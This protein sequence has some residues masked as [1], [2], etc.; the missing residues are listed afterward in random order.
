VFSRL[1]YGALVLLLG[2]GLLVLSRVPQV[3]YVETLVFAALG[4][5]E[6]GVS[7]PVVRLDQIGQSVQN[8]GQ[9]QSDNA[10]LRAEVDSLT[11]QAVLVP[12]LQRENALLRAELGFSRDNPQF[13]WISAHLLGFD[14]SNLVR[15][16]IL[17]QGSRSGVA[18]GMTVVTP[19][20]LVGQVIEV[21][22]NTSK[23]LLIAD[24][25][26]SVDA[27]VQTNRAKGIVNGSRTGRLTMTYIPQAE[28]IQ[29]GDR[30]VT[31]GLGGIYPPG[32]LVGTVTD[33]RQNDVDLFQE[34]QVEPSVDFGRLEEVMIIVNHL[35]T[36][37]R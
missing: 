3:Q 7:I 2:G 6:I 26:S 12:E 5:L 32:L 25:S 31:S 11:Q 8:I 30:I 23:I 10:R 20:G 27:L 15:A 34:A 13:H 14:P 9:L 36:A 24:V 37:L 33:V 16:A 21:T 22:P 29:T 1:A 18:K 17:D 28:K 35:P 4:P 19:S